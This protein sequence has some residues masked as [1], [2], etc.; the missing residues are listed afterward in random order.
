MRDVWKWIVFA[1]FLN[2]IQQFFNWSLSCL[3]KLHRGH[4]ELGYVKLVL[5]HFVNRYV[6]FLPA[7][8]C[9][10]LF[11][12]CAQDFVEQ[13][14]LL[15]PKG[16]ES[17]RADIEQ[18]MLQLDSRQDNY[19]IGETRVRYPSFLLVLNAHWKIHVY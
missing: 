9:R 19:Q 4:S 16:R 2:C 17:S 18:F 10:L 11:L 15:L 1:Q 12:R 13:Y 7:E 14:H 6:G 5:F 3:L 8:P